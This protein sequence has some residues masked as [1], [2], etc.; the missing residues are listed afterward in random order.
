[1]KTNLKKYLMI[2]PLLMFVA[3]T[4]ASCK[5]DKKDEPQEPEITGKASA[6]IGTWSWSEPLESYS[7][8]FKADGTGSEKYTLYG[9]TDVE[10]FRWSATDYTVTIKYN[11]GEKWVADYEISGRVLYL[12]GDELYKN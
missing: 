3:V 12:D 5:D 9:E 1:M 2:L 7:I 8:T 6:L 10:S 11:D 4:M